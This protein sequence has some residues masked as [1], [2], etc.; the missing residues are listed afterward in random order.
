M[1]NYDVL[2]NGTITALN[3]TVEIVCAGMGTV[4]L[5]VSGTWVG[6]L[7]AE[8][9]VGDGV[10]DA[11]PLV[12]NTLAGAVLSITANGNWL[13][14]VAGALTLR[15]RASLWTSGTAVIYLN[16]SAAAAGVFLSRS[17]PTGLNSIGT[18]G[19]DSI[20]DVDGQQAMAASLPVVIAS[21]QSQVYVKQRGATIAVTPTVTAGA[22]S[23]NDCVGG[24]LTFANAARTAGEGGFITDVS[25]VDDAGQDVA[26]ELWLFDQTITSPGDN[27]AWAATEADLHNLVGIWATDDGQWRAAGTPSVCHLKELARFQAIGTSLFGQLVTRG[28]PTFAATDDVTVKIKVAQDD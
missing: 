11:I 8:I 7:V 27:A 16:A 26:L 13:L 6:T 2:A 20:A 21:D 19:I 28:T 12:E 1:T 18:I 4:G 15:I 23:A 10:W 9:E 14:G 17:I 22:Y 3:G 25:I 5:G 24:E